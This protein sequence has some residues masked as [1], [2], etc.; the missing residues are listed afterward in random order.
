MRW[1]WRGMRLGNHRTMQERHWV[2][3]RAVSPGG[4]GHEDRLG[5]GRQR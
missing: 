5:L 1:R 2:A 4:A 3:S